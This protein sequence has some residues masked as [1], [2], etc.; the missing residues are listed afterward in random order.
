[1]IVHH[2]T[3]I[4]NS[5]NR[6]I[7]ANAAGELIIDRLILNLQCIDTW[8]HPSKPVLTLYFHQLNTFHFSIDFYRRIN[9]II[10]KLFLFI[11]LKSFINSD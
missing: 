10:Q 8:F 11:E 4:D 1:M 6:F 2:E 7:M 3:M 9:T 5:S